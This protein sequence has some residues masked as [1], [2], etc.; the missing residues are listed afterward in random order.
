MGELALESSASC[1]DLVYQALR[2]KPPA[3]S[4]REE[5]P[6]VWLVEGEQSEGTL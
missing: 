3:P 5:R 4:R 2:W 1:E 6:P